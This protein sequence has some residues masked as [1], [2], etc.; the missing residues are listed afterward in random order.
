M[1]RGTLKG[2]PEDIVMEEVF[3]Y[4]AELGGNPLWVVDAG[5][6]VEADQIVLEAI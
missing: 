5:I 3:R 2:Q 1:S 4:G 6:N